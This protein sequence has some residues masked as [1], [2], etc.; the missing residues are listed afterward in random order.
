MSWRRRWR[1]WIESLRLGSAL[2]LTTSVQCVPGNDDRMHHVTKIQILS[3]RL[4]G[5]LEDSS[6]SGE[7]LS[8]AWK[9]RDWNSFSEEYL[10]AAACLRSQDSLCI[11]A[12][13]QVSGHAIECALKACL[14]STGRPV[15]GTHD[16]VSLC[17]QVEMAGFHVTEMQALALF[18]L[19]LHY[20]RDVGTGT[21]FKSRYPMEKS[22]SSETPIPVHSAVSQLVESLLHQSLQ[23]IGDA[24]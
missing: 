17:G 23:K 7:Q 13:L 15:P 22:E 12:C 6:E 24:V 4:S 16:L 3:H 18:Q 8:T 21:K 2:S 20:F 9:V 11:R 1:G 19:S 14:A 5:L 10:F